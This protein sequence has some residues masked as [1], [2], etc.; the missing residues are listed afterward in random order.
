MPQ[1][2]VIMPVY[3]GEMYLA[4][5]IDSILEQT[6]E[7][8]ELIIVDDCSTDGS[9][10]IL[11]DYASRD[12]RIR[13][14]QH[15]RNR[16]SASAR[17]SGIAASRGE[18]IAAMDCDDISL[19]QRLEKQV[20]FLRSLPNTAVVGSFLQ[21]VSA[22][23]TGLW[24][25]KYPQQHALIVLYWGI[26]RGAVAGAA[27]MARRD[28]LMSV[29]GYEESS[30]IADDTALFS[31]LFWKTRFANLPHALYQYRHHDEQKSETLRQKQL[32][33]VFAINQRWL[34]RLW[35][36]A[37]AATMERFQRL[38]PHEKL[39]WAERRAAKKDLLRLIESLIS[40]NLVDQCDEP[41]MVTAINRLLEQASPRIWQQFM[42]WRRHR[43]GF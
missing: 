43:L 27:F 21:I 16:G 41:L 18:F 29:G 34:T 25:Q 31:R 39:G 15:N 19:P 12:E 35:G 14:I 30:K 28:I 3:N 17:N 7:D 1:V 8:F 36:E 42:H 33:E 13:L 32:T 2:S 9:A 10:A 24:I 20:A 38:S 23:K 40:H 4:E 37:P 5:G 6:F 26:G 11:R 22:D